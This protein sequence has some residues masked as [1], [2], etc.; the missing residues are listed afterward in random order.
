MWRCQLAFEQPL[1]CPTL[2]LMS[3]ADLRL[4]TLTRLACTYAR[5]N[6]PGTPPRRV[7]RAIYFMEIYVRLESCPHVG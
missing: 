1:V 4:G 6:N 3:C 7:L 5:I 2:L